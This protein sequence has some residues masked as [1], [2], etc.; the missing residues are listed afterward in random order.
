[1][2]VWPFLKT[3]LNLFVINFR[4]LKISGS[5]AQISIESEQAGLI[6]KFSFFKKRRKLRLKTLST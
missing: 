3:F 4:F 5:S 6:F 1:M 2:L